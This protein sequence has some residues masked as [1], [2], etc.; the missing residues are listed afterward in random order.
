MMKF[1][2]NIWDKVIKFV[3]KIYKKADALADKY[4]PIAIDVVEFIKNL[5]ES[6]E[7]KTTLTYYDSRYVIADTANGKFYK[8]TI[9]ST[10]GVASIILTEV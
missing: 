3:Q 10:N 8:H 2:K 1:F 5:N 7:G 9:R 4:Y 6:V